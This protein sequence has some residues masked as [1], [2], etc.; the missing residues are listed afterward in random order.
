MPPSHPRPED[1]AAL[2]DALTATGD[3]CAA[4][5]EALIDHLVTVGDHATQAAL[6][7]TIDAA[8]DVL[9]ELSATCRELSLALSADAAPAR[10]T[11]RASARVQDPR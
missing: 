10:R 9:R 6:E 7:T 3:H 5:G 2:V 1:A 11:S 8:V 4:E